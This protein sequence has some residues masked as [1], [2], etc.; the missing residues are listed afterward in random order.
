MMRDIKYNTNKYYKV[1]VND[2][3][4]FSINAIE[5]IIHNG[6]ESR[7]CNCYYF[8]KDRFYK[9]RITIYDEEDTPIIMVRIWD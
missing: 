9:D 1:L 8:E 3:G 4:S 5:D 7:I 2:V 6:Y